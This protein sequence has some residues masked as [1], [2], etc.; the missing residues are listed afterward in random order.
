MQGLA[1]SILLIWSNLFRQPES[2]DQMSAAVGEI[3]KLNDQLSQLRQENINL[4]VSVKAM[5]MVFV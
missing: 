3:K 2:S 4:K 1:G 5:E